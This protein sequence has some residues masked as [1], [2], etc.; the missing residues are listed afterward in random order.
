MKSID[1]F[2]NHLVSYEG[3]ADLTIETSSANLDINGYF[4]AAQFPSGRLI[5]NVVSTKMPKPTG[6]M[7]FTDTEE[8]LSFLGESLDGWTITCEG[9]NNFSLW[10]WLMSP[11]TRHP[12]EQ[13]FHPEYL[14]SR[15]R[16]ISVENYQKVVFL[17]SNLLWYDP[18][19]E[20]PEAVELTANDYRISIDPL[21]GYT[22]VANRLRHT[23]GIHPTARVTLETRDAASEPLESFRNAIDELIYVL[24]LV[25]GNSVQWYYGEAS[26]DG[27][28]RPVARIH[29][30]TRARPYSST[31]RL[32]PP[33]RGQ[34]FLV[35]KL[36]LQTLTD[37]YLDESNHILNKAKL[38]ELID[39]FTNT[40][41]ETSFL[42]MRGL[43]A[44]TLTDMLSSKFAYYRG[45]SELV[46]K[47]QF[48]S[49]HFPALKA[50]IDSA[51]WPRRIKG[52]LKRFLQGGYRTGFLKRLGGMN[53][54]LKIGLK[55]PE[56]K[57]IV[58]L[59]D[60]LVHEGTFN[61]KY[62]EGNW[63]QDYEL[64]TWINLCTLCRMTGYTGQLPKFSRG[65][66]I[67]V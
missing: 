63:L 55:D 54:D 20:K 43:L 48:D 38:K 56:I 44:A 2:G 24:R 52:D 25:T 10:N 32:R 37:A 61:S 41:D 11:M 66:S 53:K 45:N 40:C 46:P 33:K 14:L 49:I 51:K 17:V 65:H 60:S 13:R 62:E 57:H 27:S 22:D 67:E 6:P 4:E 28:D 8:K 12:S 35:P 36:D 58:T 23:H 47:D 1:Q 3:T 15:Q 50:T 31:I 19:K 30:Q 59:R 42:E 5:V 39:Q 29:Q 7:S 16:T 26:L 34:Q 64:M 9:E 21:E 18:F